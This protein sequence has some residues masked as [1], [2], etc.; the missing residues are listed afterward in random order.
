MRLKKELLFFVLAVFCT[1]EAFSD[2]YIDNNL[3]AP[4]YNPT[5]P[6]DSISITNSST[7]SNSSHYI[8]FGAH[9]GNATINNNGSLTST[10]DNS[11]VLF[12]SGYGNSTS[13]SNASLVINNNEGAT[14]HNSGDGGSILSITPNTNLKFDLTFNNSGTLLADGEFANIIVA[15]RFSSVNGGSTTIN[16]SGTISK[17]FSGDSTAA[18]YLAGGENFVIN[19]SGTL[20]AGSS[21]DEVIRISTYD[22]V[23]VNVLE[24]S[25]IVGNIYSNATSNVLNIQKSVNYSQ[26][27]ALNGQL[28]GSSWTTNI[29]SGGTLTLASSETINTVNSTSGSSIVNGGTITN[30]NINS[31]SVQNSGTIDNAN[32]NGGTVTNTGA[33][34]T[35]NANSGTSITNAGYISSLVTSGTVS[36]SL[37]APTIPG[38]IPTPSSVPGGSIDS[39]TNNGTLTISLN[40]IP[41]VTSIGTHPLTSSPIGEITNN[42]TLYFSGF[43]NSNYIGNIT[44][45]GGFTKSGSDIYTVS[46]TQNYSGATIVSSG[47]LKVNGSIASSSLTTVNSGAKI[48]GTGTVGNL[49]IN[50]DATLA[51]GNSIGTMNVAGNLTLNSGSNTAIEYNNVAMD[52]V[53]ASGNIAVAGTANFSIYN[54][55]AQKNFVV[56]QNILETTG[57]TLSGKFDN[58]A[59]DQD[60]FLISTSYSSTAA[61]ATI[62]KKLNS[63]TLDAP[64]FVQNSIG[65]MIGSSIATHLNDNRNLEENKTTS[66]VSTSAFNGSRGSIQNSSPFSTNGYLLSAGMVKSYE[67][68]QITGSVFNS[69]A[70]ANRYSYFGKDEIDTN[71]F[72]LGLGKAFG[73]FYNSIQVGAGFYNSNNRRHVEVNGVAQTARS[74][75]DGNFKYIN[76][77]T[78]YNLDLKDYG[79]IIM[80]FSAALQDNQN[81]GFSENGLSFGNYSSSKSSAKTTNLEAGI[82][83]RNEFARALKLPQNSF[84]ELGFNGYQS[85][86]HN[87]KAATISQGNAN[88]QLYSQYRQGLVFG[89]S[90]LAS[91]PLNEATRVFAKLERRQNGSLRDNIGSLELNYKF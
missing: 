39:I 53:I 66:W 34:T 91:L 75:S 25:E 67:D 6:F 33:I 78:A 71:G 4:I 17:T 12:F 8:Y 18:I 55:D 49:T 76:A 43:G 56:S 73:D 89:A 72:A 58:V 62:S 9:H 82:S 32:I 52:K 65:R 48:S 31:G 84:F 81:N 10:N 57:G 13:S 15:T 37:T 63:S 44:G 40:L 70:S 87:K 23:T 2:A 54:F 86:I 29:A 69:Y 50:S 61:R 28:T 83:Y 21:S 27:N 79:K 24:G 80:S 7:L 60:Q 16:N 74:N 41:S 46:S 64:L 59:I 88:Y 1:K 47:E 30:A 3:S 38:S 85:N 5:A 22:S 51:P 77:A 45:S 26:Y 36:L 42:G 14:M 68:F 90:A 35:L 19:N 11:N 20:E